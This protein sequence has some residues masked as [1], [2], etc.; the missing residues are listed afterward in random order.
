MNKR[1]TLEELTDKVNNA[2]QIDGYQSLDKRHKEITTG[3]RIR[4]YI[5]KGIVD[6]A[7]KD[8]RNVYYTNKHYEQVLYCRKLQ[9]EGL[10]DQF[11]KKMVDNESANTDLQFNSYVTHSEKD[12]FLQ[13]QAKSTLDS[14][15]S[16]SSSGS[17]VQINS[18]KQESFSALAATSA[19]KKYIDTRSIANKKI[20][21][22]EQ[23]KLLKE[24]PLDKDGKIFLKIEDNYE[25]T[26]PE[27]I[28]K[29]IKS[30]LKLGE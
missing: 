17:A 3:R 7:E 10:N 18:L 13:Q 1:M 12:L 22:I 14:L 25:I 29:K 19:T 6:K 15:F 23:Y 30:I 16:G 26:D 4:D 20:E 27:E 28:L 24:Y 21:V 5:S 8:G 11:I 9:Q 2:M